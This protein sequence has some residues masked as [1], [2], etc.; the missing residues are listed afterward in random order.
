MKQADTFTPLYKR[1]ALYDLFPVTNVVSLFYRGLPR[2]RTVE[3][4]D[5]H[6]DFWELF[7]VDRGNI[8]IVLENKSFTLSSG[9]GVLY[10][11]HSTHR[12]IGSTV[13]STNVVS[14][15][16]DCPTLNKSFFANK[17]CVFNALEK[18]ILS[19]LINI[20][21]SY[22][23]RFSND[24]FGEKGTKL[25][26][27]APDFAIPFVKA[28]IEYL[29]LLFYHKKPV[30]NFEKKT[31]RIQLSPAITQ[32]VDF[33]YQNVEK[34]LTIDNIAAFVKMSCTQ[35]RTQFVKEL[36][37]SVIDYF[38]D[39]KVE[40]AKIL[41]REDVYS[42]SEI[43]FKLGYSSESYFSRQFKQKTNM[44]PSEYARLVNYISPTLEEKEKLQ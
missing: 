15:S 11:P 9:Q 25:K 35:F 39:I 1:V 27:N 31:A 2:K 40:Q 21:N 22:F 17:L 10:A 24:P 28:S 19:N 34:K 6:N 38:N 43:A 42:F 3:I 20:G 7:Y 33:M 32:A 16:F 37:H 29:L 5:T 44:T 23:E 4:S 30:S 13:D 12:L 18:N 14:I 8:S 26:E 41:I 36:G